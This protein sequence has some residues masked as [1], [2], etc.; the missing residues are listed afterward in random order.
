MGGVVSVRVDGPVGWVVFSRGGKLNAMS[1]ELLSGARR[2]LRELEGRE[3]VFFAVFRG[4]GRAFSAGAD[5]G[6]VA[7]AGS[8]EELSRLFEELVGLVGDL[9]S[10]RLI[11][12]AAVHGLAV[13][14]GA[15]VLWAFD[16]VVATRDARLRW[17]EA[18]WG[19]VAPGLTTLGPGVLGPQRALWLAL[20][21]GELSGEEA[22]RLGL[23]SVLVESEGELEGAVKGLVEAVMRNEPVAARR[24]VELVREWKRRSLL[25]LGA[26]TLVSLSR[27]G[28]VAEA[29]RSFV[30]RRAPPGYEWR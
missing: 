4:E 15:E 25:P 17:P 3:G 7:S 13:G 2:A 6:E 5:L 28:V 10:T 16:F 20:G 24:S 18:L 9:L 30:E 29:A 8:P 11:T 27:R 22:Y 23:V 21:G 19:L 12:V 1:V 14:G 26:E